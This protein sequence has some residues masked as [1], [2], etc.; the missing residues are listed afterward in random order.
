MDLFPLI[1]DLIAA[2]AG[3]L[4][5]A[6]AFTFLFLFKKEIREL[7]ARIKKGNIFGNEFEFEKEVDEFSESVNKASQ[8]IPLNNNDE[9]IEQTKQEVEILGSS[10]SDPRIGVL[11]LAREIEKEVRQLIAGMGLS[12]KSRFQGIR[13][14]FIILDERGALP[15]HTR[16]SLEIFW[17][18]RNEIVHGKVVED[19]KNV[20]RVLDIGMTLLNAL[21]SI[22]HEINT[23]HTLAV[24]IFSDE[25]CNEARQDVKGVILETTSPGGIEKTYR[26]FPTTKPSYYI[27]GRRVS[28]E[29]NMSNVWGESWYID[30]VTREKK[31]AWLSSGEFVGRHMEE[32]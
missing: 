26:I 19:E 22:P 9:S 29:W 3:V 25:K 13:D 5:P 12:G 23:V 8:E 1:N 16:G 20:I 27:K 7:L 31:S 15:K 21:R 18:L 4:W 28:W 11:I 14:L 32:I 2:L 24:D 10:V 6:F 17:K 30:P